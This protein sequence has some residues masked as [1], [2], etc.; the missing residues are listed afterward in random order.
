VR[1]P[2]YDNED[3]ARCHAR[4]LPGVPT[5]HERERYCWDGGHG[6]PVLERFRRLGRALSE[7]EY[8]VLIGPE[9]AHAA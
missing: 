8:L 2:L 3:G 6:C 9:P 7:R 1:C 4:G 5:L